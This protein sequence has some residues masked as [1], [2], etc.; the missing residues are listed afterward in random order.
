MDI[1]QLNN[2]PSVPMAMDGV[3][4]VQMQLL[5]GP[6][7]GAGNFA[8]RVFTVAPGGHTPAHQ[9]PY[10]HEVL[11]LAGTGEAMQTDGTWHALKTGDTLWVPG[12][13]LHQFR[14]NGSTELKFLCMV[15][16]HV[17]GQVVNC[18]R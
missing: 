9:H 2:I 18:A 16:A 11:I 4:D 17:H 10:E 7:D 13:T 5:W 1:K 14:N 6:Q 15:P 12:N 3:K 8:M